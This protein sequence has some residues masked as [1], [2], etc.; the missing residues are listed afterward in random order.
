MHTQAPC[1]GGDG[2]VFV[3]PMQQPFLIYGVRV[4]SIYKQGKW[5]ARI[6][7]ACRLYFAT[8][9][10]NIRASSATRGVDEGGGFGLPYPYPYVYAW[11]A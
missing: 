1:R 8:A 4:S 5:S 2:N 6:Y 3:S 7:S 9:L 10:Y 11:Y